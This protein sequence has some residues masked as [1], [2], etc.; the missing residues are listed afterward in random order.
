MVGIR[1][2]ESLQRLQ[3]IAAMTKAGKTMTN[4]K[5]IFPIYD[6]TNN[7]VWLYLKQE[8]VDIPEIYLFFVAIRKFKAAA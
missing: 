8:K 3:N 1:T 4:K 5:Q 7:D 6:W 2:A